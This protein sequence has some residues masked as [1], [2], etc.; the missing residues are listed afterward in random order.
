MH[1]ICDLCLC[2]IEHDS[3]LD[4]DGDM[5]LHVEDCHKL[6]NAVVIDFT[7]ARE[8]LAPPATLERGNTRDGHIIRDDRILNAANVRAVTDAMELNEDHWGGQ[9]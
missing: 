2:R 4:V 6:P 1:S 5:I 8:R 9:F 3:P 7:S